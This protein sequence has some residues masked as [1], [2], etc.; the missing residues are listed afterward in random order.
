MSDL[1]PTTAMVDASHTAER[2]H[3]QAKAGPATG[4]SRQVRQGP[5]YCISVLHRSPTAPAVP[6]CDELGQKGFDVATVLGLQGPAGLSP[7]IVARLQAI[8][9]S[10]MR[11]PDMAAR[12]QQFGMVMEE[13]GTA[14]YMEFMK[15]DMDRYA[16]A[17]KRLNLQT[18]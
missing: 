2:C 7:K 17:V 10:A 4:P 8:A 1:H 6:T 13:N 14:N 3:F 15:S 5:G 18:R 12:M 16:Q 9:A 11:E